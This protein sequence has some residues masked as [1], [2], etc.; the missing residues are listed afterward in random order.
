MCFPSLLS[1][2][3][4]ANLLVHFFMHSPLNVLVSSLN[5]MLSDL[6]FLWSSMLPAIRLALAV[7][8]SFCCSSSNCKISGLRKSNK[9]QIFFHY[10]CSL[11]L[12]KPLWTYPSN[13]PS[14]LIALA[15]HNGGTPLMPDLF[16]DDCN[17]LKYDDVLTQLSLN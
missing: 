2:K 10:P 8:D 11:W 1:D 7:V 16:T 12:L 6:N 4:S 17:L 15:C 5:L 14:L 13:L 3:F 9:I